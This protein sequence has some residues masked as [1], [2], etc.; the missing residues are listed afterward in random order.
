M[1]TRDR[2]TLQ[3]K[4]LTRVVLVGGGEEPVW[5][6]LENKRKESRNTASEQF[7]LTNFAK[8]EK[9]TDVW[10]GEREN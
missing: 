6:E 10:E 4:M 3:L 2:V 1:S 9:E 7:F 8:N 5:S